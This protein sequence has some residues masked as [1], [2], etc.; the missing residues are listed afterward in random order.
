MIAFGFPSKKY[1]YRGTDVH[2]FVNQSK[3]H[4]SLVG[5]KDNYTRTSLRGKLFM[6][7]T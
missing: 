6:E 7:P 3:F 2:V 5:L 4:P 1:M